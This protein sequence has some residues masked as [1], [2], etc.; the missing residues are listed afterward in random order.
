MQEKDVV[1]INKK[2]KTVYNI[3]SKTKLAD[4]PGKKAVGQTQKLKKILEEFFAP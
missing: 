4:R 1:I 3:E 2:T